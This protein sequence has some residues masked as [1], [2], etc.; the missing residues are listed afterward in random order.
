MFNIHLLSKILLKAKNEDTKIAETQPLQ[1]GCL[2]CSGG[3]ERKS[4][5]V[6]C[7]MKTGEILKRSSPW[8]DQRTPCLNW[9][10][11]A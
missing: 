5:K 1:S 3:D 6:R 10:S 2:Q 7:Q 9:I 4:I 8:E 11:K